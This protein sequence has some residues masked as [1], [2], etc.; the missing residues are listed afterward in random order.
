MNIFSAANLKKT[1]YYMKRNG[2]RKTIYAMRERVGHGGQPPY[3]RQPVSEQ[4]K[5][6]QREHAAAGFSHVSFSIVVPVYRTPESYLK[7]MIESVIKQTYPSWELILADATEDI[8]IKSVTADTG[9]PA[10]TKAA[11][12]TKASADMKT[13]AG[14]KASAG[15]KT[16]AD[17]MT[18]GRIRAVAEAYGEERIR[19][20]HLSSNDGIAENTNQGIAQA[21]GDY[22]GLLDHD[23]LLEENALYEMAAIIERERE[24]GNELQI[25]YSDEDKCNGDGTEYYDPNYKEDFNLDLLLSTT[26][27]TG[28]IKG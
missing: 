10:D 24:K 22:V 3:R 16:A 23:D 6:K 15:T 27:G 26:E 13:P 11:E 5:K 21:A 28:G 25:I 14:T 19:Y 8:D 2:L 12:G 9:K 7:E 17:A 20:F 4:E 18:A 1:I